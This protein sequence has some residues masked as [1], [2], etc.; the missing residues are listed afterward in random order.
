MAGRQTTEEE[1][2]CMIFIYFR[3]SSRGSM[4]EQGEVPER[5]R[6]SICTSGGRGRGRESGSQADSML[7]MKSLLRAPS[8]D[9]EAQD[10][11]QNKEP[12]T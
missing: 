8:Q 11:N 4:Y 12:T 1:C 7:S 3:K 2:V 6:A 10:L 5:Q 9:P